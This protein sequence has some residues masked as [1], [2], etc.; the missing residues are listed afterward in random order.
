MMSGE[1]T[2]HTQE[3]WVVSERGDDSVGNMIDCLKSSEGSDS[4]WV[5]IGGR[6]WSIAYA[7]PTNAHLIAAA[8]ELLEACKALSEYI[9]GEGDPHAYTVLD[10]TCSAIKKAEGRT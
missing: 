10:I 5:S 4:E 2:K 6:G 1:L 9:I 8:P 3:S 7:H